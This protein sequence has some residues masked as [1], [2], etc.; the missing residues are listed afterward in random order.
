MCSHQPARMKPVKA[1][2]WL[3]SNSIGKAV[4]EMLSDRALS[5]PVCT[6]PRKDGPAEGYILPLSSNRCFR[7][8][9]VNSLLFPVPA[10]VPALL[11][12]RPLGQQLGNPW[13]TG[14]SCCCQH[15]MEQPKA[16]SEQER[17]PGA[18]GAQIGCCSISRHEEAAAAAQE[19][20]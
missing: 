1:S 16:H 9:G 20:A 19:E 4:W 18:G 17:V 10:T 14:E 5:F 12:P 7:A 8:L 13:K 6:I 2:T 3:L 15:E 11:P